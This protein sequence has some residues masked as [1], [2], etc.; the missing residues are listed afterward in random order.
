MRQNIYRQDIHEIRESLDQ[1]CKAIL[2]VLRVDVTIVDDEFRRMT[3]TGRYSDSI[4][5]Y[6]HGRGVFQKALETGKSQVVEDPRENEI[7]FSCENKPHCVEFA[8][9]CCPIIVEG[10]TVGVLGLAAFSPEQKER[11]LSEK[12]NMISFV[13]SMAGLLATKV[14]ENSE[15][16]RIALMAAELSLLVDSMDSGVIITDSEGRLLRYNRIADEMLE[17]GANARRQNCSPEDLN[18]SGLDTLMGNLSVR[19]GEFSETPI[20]GREFTYRENQRI[21]R[22]FI[23]AKPISSGRGVSGYLFMLTAANEIIKV[24]DAVSGG[25]L[26]TSFHEILGDSELITGLKHHALKIAAGTSTVL[27]LGES[28]TGKELFA[29]AI[30][31]SSPRKSGPFIA[32]NCSAIPES[33][34]ESELFGYEEGAF[35]G[36]RRSGRMGKFELASQGTIFLDEIGDMPLNLQTKLLR[37][38]QENVIERVGGNTQITVNVRVIAATNKDLD[39]MVRE[40]EFRQDLYYRLNVIPIQLP[41]L[42]ERTSDIEII[43]GSFLKKYNHK[44]GRNIRA[45]GK[46]AL[47]VLLS[48]SWPGNVRELENAIEYSVNVC[49]RDEIHPEE[50]PRRV[51]EASTLP[52]PSFSDEMRSFS[53]TE[54]LEI[55]RALKVAG[56]PEKAAKLL[57]IGRATIYR[58]MKKYQLHPDSIIHFVSK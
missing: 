22:G 21:K 47:R 46:S 18:I 5:E 1:V 57:G 6:L 12:I 33:L 7:C 48:Y 58:K 35:T 37:V 52:I 24:I 23:N 16:R 14:R 27:L 13:E 56:T 15:G 25:Q 50:L 10:T 43:A 53:E 26:P 11:L 42:R 55:L 4:G 49:Q 3:G 38:L 2:S 31:N 32:L 20:Y 54:K 9:V 40:K 44:L 28:G 8:Q 51:R 39:Q 29:R 34:I 19:S 41:P 36:A 30:H 17:I 45:I